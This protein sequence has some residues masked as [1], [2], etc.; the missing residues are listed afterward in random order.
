M[1][2]K[3]HKADISERKAKCPLMTHN[4]HCHCH[5]GQRCDRAPPTYYCGGEEAF[6]G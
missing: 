6:T 5:H 4:G 1:S 2:A 3:Q